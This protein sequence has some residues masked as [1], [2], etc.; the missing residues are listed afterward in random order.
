MTNE[1]VENTV[2]DQNFES[3]NLEGGTARKPE[4]PFG[5][6]YT[7]FPEYLNEEAVMAITGWS[8]KT[9]ANK[10]SLREIPFFKNECRKIIYPKKEIFNYLFSDCTVPAMTRRENVHIKVEDHIRKSRRKLVK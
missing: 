8:A 4:N 5:F 6:N 2:K 7:D 9:L 1:L 3:S 10:R